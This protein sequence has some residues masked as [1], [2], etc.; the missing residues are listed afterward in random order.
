MCPECNSCRNCKKKDK[1]NFTRNHPL[2]LEQLTIADSEDDNVRD[3]Q[4]NNCNISSDAIALTMLDELLSYLE[5]FENKPYNLIFQMLYD[6]NTIQ[7]SADTL[8]KPWSTVNDMVKK[9]RKL[10]QKYLNSNK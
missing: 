4:D 8:D 3:I 6:Q 5:T 10:V 9:V 2:S 1:F 7:E